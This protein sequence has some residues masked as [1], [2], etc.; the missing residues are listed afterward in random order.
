LLFF[1]FLLPSGT[2]FANLKGLSAVP[3]AVSAGAASVEGFC[4]IP[5]A[6]KWQGQTRVWR[7]QKVM[8]AKA[9]KALVH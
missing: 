2:S 3:E 1:L 7:E 6:R 4:G 5:E 8:I 9:S